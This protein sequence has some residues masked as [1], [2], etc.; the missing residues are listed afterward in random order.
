MAGEFF[1]TMKKLLVHLLVISTCATTLLFAQ[2]SGNP[3]SAADLVQ[4]R[5]EFL[6]NRLGLSSAQQQQAT[7]IFTNSAT[8]EATVRDSLR[9][10]HQSL[11]DA[12][13]SNDSAA[14]DRASASI[15]TLTAQLTSIGA[16]ADAAF[17]Q[18]LTPDQQTKFSQ[19][20]GP[21]S[22]GF[23]RGAGPGGFRGR[24]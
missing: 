6:T 19:S 3:P 17:Y 23:G 9:T 20:P 11:N 14:I 18:I 22:G 1:R 16:K 13:K 12:V 4:R 8:S 15:G 7:T 21:G 5:V 24:Q 2:R 10:A